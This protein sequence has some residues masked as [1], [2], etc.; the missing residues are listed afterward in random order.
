VSNITEDTEVADR[1]YL[2]QRQSKHPSTLN[3][4]E[5]QTLICQPSG[6]GEAFAKVVI[7]SALCS[8]KLLTPQLAMLY[9]MKGNLS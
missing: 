9:R 8:G 5:Y 3:F 7:D 1:V 6:F 2:V 4:A